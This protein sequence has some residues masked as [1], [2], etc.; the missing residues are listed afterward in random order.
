MP[1]SRPF[2]RLAPAVPALAM[3]L[4]ACTETA[5]PVPAPDSGLRV[6]NATQTP[7]DVLVDG[8]VRVSGLPLASVSS[9][10][11]VPAG[12]RRVQLRAAGG[13][14]TELAVD[15]P[16]GSAVTAVALRSGTGALAAQVLAD[17]GA[18]VPAGKSKLRVAHLAAS[19]AANVE[20]FRTQPDFRTPV[21][22]MTPFRYGETSPYLQG[23]PGV[24]EVFVAPAGSS[25]APKGATTG[26]V[27]V[28]ADERRTVVLLDSAG[29]LRFRV[30]PE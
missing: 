25:G 6:V 23:D 12:T 14:T 29:V 28:P 13:A 3:V 21:R 15:A 16:V 2:P 24:W 27:T 18:L 11:G 1:S 17:T 8:A 20:L 9:A 26:P 4:A 22:I 7:V 10:F 5:G 19:G 30:I